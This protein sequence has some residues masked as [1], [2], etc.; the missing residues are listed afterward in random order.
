MTT[1]L[2]L[3]KMTSES[4]RNHESMARWLFEGGVTIRRIAFI[5]GKSYEWTR[6]IVK[7]VAYDY[8][9]LESN[10]DAERAEFVLEPVS[11]S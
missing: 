7:D 3:R 8:S 9:E 5:L 1:M 10:D 6:R 11:I 4:A 2:S